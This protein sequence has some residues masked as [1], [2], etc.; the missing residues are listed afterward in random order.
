MKRISGEV[1]TAAIGGGCASAI[2]SSIAFDKYVK[3]FVYQ[4]PYNSQFDQVWLGTVGLLGSAAIGLAS[5]VAVTDALVGINYTLTD[6]VKAIL[7]K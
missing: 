7:K 3:N 5:G 6:G 2:I 1:L 4:N